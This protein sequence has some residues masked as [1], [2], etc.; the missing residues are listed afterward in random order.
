MSDYLE[1]KICLFKTDSQQVTKHKIRS[2]VRKFRDQEFTV[3]R[4]PNCQSL[5]CQEMVDLDEFYVD[6]LMAKQKSDNFTRRIHQKRLSDL[7]KVG[8]KPTDKILDYGCSKGLFISFLQAKGYVNVFGY[9]AYV[10]EYADT[11]ILNEKYDLII[12]QDVIEHF[13]DP[14][15][16]FTQLV[17]CLSEKG[18]L[19]LGTPNATEINLDKAEYFLPQLHQPYHR[20]IFSEQA[21]INMAASYQLKPIKLYRRWVNDTLYPFLNSR[22]TWTYARYLENDIDV[23][24]EPIQKQVFLKHPQI[25]FYAFFGYLFPPLANIT[26]VL[27]VEAT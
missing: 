4:C 15:S 8:L 26:L 12:C 17:N 16:C 10:E 27:K 19:V 21:L 6:Y 7:I 14:R 2:N 22:C 5:H 13:E 20:H 18:I 1:C 3:W 23:F 25:L 24:F 11:S 9:D